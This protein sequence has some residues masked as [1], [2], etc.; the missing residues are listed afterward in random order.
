MK[1]KAYYYY[2]VALLELLLVVH[3]ESDLLYFHLY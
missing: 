3:K 1:Q 2:S